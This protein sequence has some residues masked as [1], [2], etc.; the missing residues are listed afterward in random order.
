MFDLELMLIETPH[1]LVKAQPMSYFS[2]I[3]L[4]VSEKVPA[5]IR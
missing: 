1:Y 4:F 2:R 5:I 3:N